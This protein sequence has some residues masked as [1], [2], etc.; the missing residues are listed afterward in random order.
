MR[1]GIAAR[2]RRRAD[3]AG[4]RLRKGGLIA[5]LMASTALIGAFMS[6]T[7]VVAIFIPVVLRIAARIGTSPGRLMMPLSVAA[8][9]SGMMTLVATAPNLVLDSLLQRQG[10]RVSGSLTSPPLACRCWRW[11]WAICWWRGAG[12]RR[13]A[14]PRR[15]S[16]PARPS[17][18]D[19]YGLADP[20]IAHSGR[21]MVS[22]DRQVAGPA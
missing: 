20:R 3:R 7:G 8:L 11:P 2:R 15:R 6:S 1:T 13:A 16:G 18:I 10:A 9:I 21:A 17:W 22:P 14:P 19:S 5:L 12:W 4:G